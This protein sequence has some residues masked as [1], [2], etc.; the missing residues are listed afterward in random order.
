MTTHARW[1][2]PLLITFLVAGCGGPNGDE[3]SPSAR[4]EPSSATP[5][6]VTPPPTPG[7]IP[8]SSESAGSATEALLLD[9]QV[10]LQ[11]GGDGVGPNCGGEQ[12]QPAA[13]K[14][15]PGAWLHALTTL[16]NYPMLTVLCLRG[17]T[18][19]EPINVTVRAGSFHAH[20]SVRPIDR[21]P[22]AESTYA[23][24]E[25][26][27]TTL[28]AGDGE[29]RVYTKDY[30][31][32]PIDG[33]PGV[34]VSEMWEF[35]PPPEARAAISKS[36]SFTLT[37]S[38]GDKSVRVTQPIATPDD[39]RSYVMADGSSRTLVLLGYPAGAVVPIGLYLTARDLS[40]KAKLVDK[41][42]SVTIPLSRVA[43]FNFDERLVDGTPPGTY[44]VEPPSG[45]VDLACS[46]LYNWPPY[47][48]A[49]SPAEEGEV[50]RKWQRIL[51][52][53]R[54]DQRPTREPRRRIRTEHPNGRAAIPRGT[55]VEQPRRGRRSSEKACTGCS[56]VHQYPDH[57]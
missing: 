33:P 4:G 28:F 14:R 32:G 49:V 50:V 35:V 52:R 48:G 23:H 16:S 6:A 34:L 24:E 9:Q 13:F 5:S 45:G 31:G 12:D 30:G 41:V 22:E 44:C 53:Y 36:G 17:F 51:H 46:Y 54:R 8:S 26:P 55:R 2:A 43:E 47:P 11:Q 27:P 20:T 21:A 29:L 18:S 39:P 56:Q 38:Q 3:R 57:R 10:R 19:Q 7:A 40:G 25:E 1:A 15:D 37:A 42:G